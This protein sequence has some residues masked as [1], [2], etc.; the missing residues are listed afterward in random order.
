MFDH[1]GKT[2]TYDYAH[3][4]VHLDRQGALP[5]YPLGFGLSYTRFEYA[6]LTLDAETLTWDQELAVSVEVTNVGERAGDEVVQLYVKQPASPIPQ[7][8]CGFGRVSLEKGE[9]KR[10]KM[11]VS[12]RD[13]ARYDSASGDLTLRA[14]RCTM[15]VG[16]HARDLPLS[17]ELTLIA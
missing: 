12:G 13:L 15:A 10:L 3:A 1:V 7:R 9:T 8:M 17:A 14:E 6:N 5:E 11:R 2:V 4:G 16:R